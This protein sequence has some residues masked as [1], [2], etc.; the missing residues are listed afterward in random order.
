MQNLCFIVY[1]E[2]LKKIAEIF[3]TFGQ[4]GMYGDFHVVNVACMGIFLFKYKY[5]NMDLCFQS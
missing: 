5:I 2:I 4:C 1:C 3:Y